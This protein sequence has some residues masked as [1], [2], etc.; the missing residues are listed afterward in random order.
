MSDLPNPFSRRSIL[1]PISEP[2]PGDE[3]TYQRALPPGPAPR[4]EPSGQRVVPTVL[5]E[6]VLPAPVLPYE[7]GVLYNMH[8]FYPVVAPVVWIRRY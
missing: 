3:S 2:T 6:P 1:D 8:Y 4:Q 5:H 7:A